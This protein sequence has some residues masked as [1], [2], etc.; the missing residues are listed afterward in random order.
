[1][2]I[3]LF[4]L[5][6]TGA[7]AC[8]SSTTPAPQPKATGSSASAAPTSSPAKDARLVIGTVKMVGTGPGRYWELVGPKGR[9]MCLPSGLYQQADLKLRYDART[10]KAPP[11][12]AR[13][14]CAQFDQSTIQLVEPLKNGNT[15]QIETIQTQNGV[16]LSYTRRVARGP[17]AM[18]SKTVIVCPP[19]EFSYR[20]GDRFK[21]TGAKIE[22]AAHA[23]CENWVWTRIERLTAR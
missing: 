17:S 8:S 20:V 16:E 11:P 7:T 12:N 4:A 23:G 6:L 3:L 21:M 5:A 18:G 9:P 19:D 15:L 10:E 13:M 2:R 1:M 14:R 22:G